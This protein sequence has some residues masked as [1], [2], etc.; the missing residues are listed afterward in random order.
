MDRVSKEKR[1]WIM[2]RIRSESSIESVPKALVGLRLRR[3]P[4][5]IPGNPDFANKKKKVALFIDGC[6]WHGC[7]K[8]FRMPRS[9]VAFWAGKI[10][11]NRSKDRATTRNLKRDGWRVIRIWEHSLKKEKNNV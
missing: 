10:R 5:G 4:R 7:P 3:H 6:F 8:H 9:N 11:R 2:S 1:S